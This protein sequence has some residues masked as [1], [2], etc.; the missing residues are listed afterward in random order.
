[1]QVDR[2][3][4]LS[5]RPDGAVWTEGGW[6]LQCGGGFE[7]GKRKRFE[8]GRVIE[9]T[10]GCRGTRS[11]GRSRRFG[12][13]SARATEESEAACVGEVVSGRLAVHSSGVSL[14]FLTAREGRGPLVGRAQTR[15]P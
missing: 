10:G 2:W 15:D 12:D 13:G 14:A 7:G 8:V 3:A 5:K 6:W 9:K 11:P 4:C 1:M